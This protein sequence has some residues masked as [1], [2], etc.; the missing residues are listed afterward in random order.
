MHEQPHNQL[1][2]VDEPSS[3]VIFD[4]VYRAGMNAN[5]ALLLDSC[6]TAFVKYLPV[7]IMPTFAALELAELLN[8]NVHDLDR[9]QVFFE[10]EVVMP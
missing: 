6:I 8:T 3:L 1:E 10:S 4:M 9:R 7:P 2:S 5:F